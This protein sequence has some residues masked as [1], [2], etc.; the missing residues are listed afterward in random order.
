MT[1]WNHNRWLPAI[2][3]RRSTDEFNAPGYTK[4]QALAVARVMERGSVDARRLGWSQARYFASRMGTA[5]GLLSLNEAYGGRW[6]EVP[7]AAAR[8]AAAA[9]EALGGN[10]VVLDVQT[11]YVANRSLKHWRPFLIDTYR[12]MM[13]DWWKGLDDWEM[14]NFAE[15][16]R[17]VFVESE[18]AVAVLT[19]APGLDDQRMLWNHEMA[20]T[21]ELLDRLGAEGRLLN[22]AVIHPD[23][24][25][26]IESMEEDVARYA[27][28]G[29]KVYT[30][31]HLVGTDFVNTAS[32]WLDDERVGLPFLERVRDVGP[33]LV[34]AHKGIS[35]MVPTGSPRDVGNAARAFP[36]IDF[37]IYH[38]GYEMPVGEE[39][40]EGPYTE[41]TANIG[42]SRLLTAVREAGVAPGSNV[43]AELGSTW[44]CL[45]RRPIE[46]AHVIG[47]LLLAVGEDNL[48]WGSDSIWYGPTQPAI[49]AF[50]AFQIPVE[51]RERYG[52]PELTPEVKA[53]VLGGNAARVYG[54]D[55]EAARRRV[56]N[57]DLS[58][59]QRAVREYEAE[60]TPTQSA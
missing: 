4:A 20:G 56:A 50:R 31:G 21:R 19:S 39:A 40:E 28:V 13:P 5:A 23:E 37:V 14:Y 47:K 46:A 26:E 12:R 34:C 57:D 6:Y 32:W 48:I 35:A 15:Y 36:E 1:R 54:I 25:T 29:W 49:D 60:G 7:D 45:I 38:A 59:V 51:L 11:H 33:R 27:P 17:C 9:E 53:K 55:A 58:W 22:H 24:P 30:I 18:T 41:E 8:D 16:L 43:Y 52:Y 42:T 3:E 44:F 2:L 10:E